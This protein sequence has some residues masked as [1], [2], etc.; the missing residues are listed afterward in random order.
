MSAKKRQIRAKF[1]EDVFSRD[2]HKCK[3]CQS[4]NELDAHHIVDRN[5]MPDGG[6]IKSNGITLCKDC[7]WKA[8]QFHRTGVALPGFSPEDLLERIK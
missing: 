5:D 7:H 2:D 6:Y 1:R 3:I 4:T 8:E